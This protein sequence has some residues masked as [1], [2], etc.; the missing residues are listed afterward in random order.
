VAQSRYLGTVLRLGE[1]DEV[2]LFN[3]RDGEWTYRIETLAKRAGEAVPVVQR[4]QA[5][6]GRDRPV[7]LFAILKRGP[8]ELL[9][10]KATELGVTRLQPVITQRTNRETHR[11]DRLSAIATEAA[12]Q[13]E[14]L[15]IPDILEPV[16]LAEAL[17]G[18]ESFVFCDEAGDRPEEPWGGDKGRAGLADAVFGSVRTPPEA[19]LIG[20][21][22]GFTPE[23]RASLRDD[24]RALPISLGPRILRA[25]T[26]GIVALTLWQARFGDLA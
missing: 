10:Q 24:E 23:E 4:R 16:P 5:E 2:R 17:G 14:R 12:E 8:T 11:L 25:E 9:V 20:P 18:L 1:G 15:S 6:D 26:A 21:E 13:C 19:I 3:G 22:G 7:L